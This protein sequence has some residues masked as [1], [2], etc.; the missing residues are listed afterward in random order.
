MDVVMVGAATLLAVDS[1]KPT[2]PLHSA[3]HNE[4]TIIRETLQSCERLLLQV[5]A[6]L[7]A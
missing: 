4:L 1:R 2:H 7:M 3:V 5:T 6:L